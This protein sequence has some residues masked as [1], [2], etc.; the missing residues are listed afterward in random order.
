MH[1]D[2]T[3]TGL[4]FQQNQI[5]YLAAYQRLSDP[6]PPKKN[7][8]QNCSFVLGKSTSHAFLN[9]TLFTVQHA[10]QSGFIFPNHPQK[11][12]TVVLNLH[13]GNQG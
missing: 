2:I 3:K 5:A 10:L 4:A 7:K 6:P 8:I 1:S 11:Q 9:K 12:V 13:V